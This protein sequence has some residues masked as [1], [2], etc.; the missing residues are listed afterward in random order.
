MARFSWAPTTATCTYSVHG[1]QYKKPAKMDM[2]EA[3]QSP[4]M[5]VN[6]VL[7]VSNGYNLFAIAPK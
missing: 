4:P 7:Y 1:K 3:L 6:G 2:E 5:A